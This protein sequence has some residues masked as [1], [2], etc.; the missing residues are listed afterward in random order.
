MRVMCGRV[1]GCAEVFRLVRLK[2]EYVAVF[3]AKS[4]GLEDSEA[5]A[6]N[7]QVYHQD[8]CQNPSK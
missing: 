2:K 1:V 8:S 7:E 4:E 3:C 6:K 5:V